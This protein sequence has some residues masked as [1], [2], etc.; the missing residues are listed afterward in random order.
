MYLMND[1]GLLYQRQQ[2]TKSCDFNVRSLQQFLLFVQPISVFVAE[3]MWCSFWTTFMRFRCWGCGAIAL[4]QV[5]QNLG[6]GGTIF[7]VQVAL[8]LVSNTSLQPMVGTHGLS[9]LLY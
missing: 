2:I 5:T 9:C 4:H 1:L 3:F 6:T 8:L 7:L